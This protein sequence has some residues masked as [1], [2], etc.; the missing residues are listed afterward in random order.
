M[1]NVIY[2][3][4]ARRVE[5]VLLYKEK[6]SRTF[7]LVNETEVVNHGGRPSYYCMT[8]LE[9][10]DDRA[11]TLVFGY[12]PVAWVVSRCTRSAY[13]ELSPR[14]QRRLVQSLIDPDTGDLVKLEMAA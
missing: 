11:S 6:G 14:W 7:Y 4:T 2:R 8:T 1:M 12:A 10:N 5:G 3:D 13:S 9:R